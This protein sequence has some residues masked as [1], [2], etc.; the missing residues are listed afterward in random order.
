M[1]LRRIATVRNG[2]HEHVDDWDKVES[3]LVF[4]SRYVKGLYH[5]SHFR[6]IWVIFGLHK[7]KGTLLRCH[8]RRDPTIPRAG[9]FATRSP[10]RPNK[11][12]LTLVRL[13]EVKGNV[14]VVRGFDAF[15]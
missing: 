12:G 2:V 9:V 14:V 3:K 7:I 10:M 8:P 11:L 4:K 13:I 1:E 15:D 5:L 6:H